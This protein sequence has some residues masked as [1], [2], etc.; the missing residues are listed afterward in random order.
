MCG[1]AGIINLDGLPVFESVLRDMNNAM[2]HRG[3]DGEGVYIDRF[4]GLAHRR[5]AIIDP[6][7]GQQPM[8]DEK[9]QL[10]IVFNG[11]IYN[12]LELKNE[13]ESYYEFI[14]GSDTEVLLKLYA[15]FG[16]QCLNKLSG[17][18]S[19][20]IYNRRSNKLF[21]ARD[22]MGIKPLYYRFVPGKSFC[23]SSELTALLPAVD[24]A[25]ID[26]SAVSDYFRWQ[27]VPTPKSIYRGISK[28]EPGHCLELD[29]DSGQLK[30]ICY[31]ELSLKQID[32]FSEHEWLEQLNNALDSVFRIYVRSDVPFGAFLS[33]GVDSSLVCALMTKQLDR[34]VRTFSIGYTEKQHSELDFAR[35][36]SS[37]IRSQHHEEIITP[38]MAKDI[39]ASIAQSFGEPF[40]D[41]SAIPT[42]F[43]SRMT[44]DRVK[45]VLSGDG[46]DELFAGYNSYAQT[47]KDSQR[48]P[49]SSA[50][51]QMIK[52]AAAVI[53]WPRLTQRLQNA[54]LSVLDKH[55]SHRQI[56]SP[57]ELE[58]LM[59]QQSNTDWPLQQVLTK[60]LG[61]EDVSRFQYLDVRTYLLDDILT[62]VDRMSM[63]HSLEIRVPLLDH[64]IVELAFRMPLSLKLRV[65]HGKVI[66]KYILKKS[67]ERFYSGSFLGRHKMGF[68]IPIVEWCRGDLQS[69]IRDR[70]ACGNSRTYD[71]V[72]R[73]TVRDMLDLFFKGQASLVAKVWTLLMFDLW[74]EGK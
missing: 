24:Q 27:Y 4:V 19:F 16:N 18:F 57:L 26:P 13:L 9:N 46:G 68:G 66:S 44:A 6:T 39:V 64:Q 41:S 1:I 56:F 47:F 71:F 8:V 53:P 69:L 43:V 12:Y 60:D 52:F 38:L 55:L 61:K 11:E 28:L 70:F 2:A 63:A 34:P 49:L 74:V 51:R 72:R 21:L 29:L 5:L 3:P 20:A 30:N 33:G 14:T 36:V 67:A 17:M 48:I 15:Y 50:M 73:D 40:A 45:M 23:F 25:E 62:K 58:S 31:W 54:T 7:S 65:I 10:S 35:Q 59:R 32:S 37:I 42:Y 22:R